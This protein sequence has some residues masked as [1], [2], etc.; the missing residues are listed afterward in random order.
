MTCVAFSSAKK[1][2]RMREIKVAVQRVFVPWP[3]CGSPF[4]WGQEEWYIVSAH[5]E[6]MPISPGVSHLLVLIETHA[7]CKNLLPLPPLNCSFEELYLKL[8][9]YK[10]VVRGGPSADMS[11]LLVVS[12]A[13]PGEATTLDKGNG[14]PAK[15]K[16]PLG[17]SE[18]LQLLLLLQSCC[19]YCGCFCPLCCLSLCFPSQATTHWNSAKAHM[20]GAR[21]R[22]R[23]RQRT[24]KHLTDFCPHQWW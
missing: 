9:T 17:F 13:R 16:H 12:G 2:R 10:I 21:E 3:W 24:E 23:D 11:S 8:S 19:F 15:K 20:P 5:L 14:A 18:L 4:P 22:Q 7:T 1:R 6:T